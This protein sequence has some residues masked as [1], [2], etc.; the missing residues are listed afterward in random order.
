MKTKLK[1]YTM[2][3][4]EK[5]AADAME[6]GGPYPS[7]KLVL[8]VRALEDAL[9]MVEYYKAIGIVLEKTVENLQKELKGKKNGNVRRSKSR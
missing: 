8:T 7:D 6:Q 3:E 9:T 2:A 5:W 4:L 1:P